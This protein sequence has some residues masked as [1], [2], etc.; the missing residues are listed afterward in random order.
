MNL[1]IWILAG[2]LIGWLGYSYLHFNE[3]RGKMISIVIGTAGGV[4]G[5][6]LLA[7]IF[8]A[9]PPTGEFSLAALFFAAA[10]AAAFLAAGNLV[11]NRWGI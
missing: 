1:V 2:A 5:G 10:L 7:P 11:H 8:T 6:K 9:A 4:L 3:A